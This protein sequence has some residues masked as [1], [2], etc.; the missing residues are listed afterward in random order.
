VLR[1]TVGWQFHCLQVACQHVQGNVPQSGQSSRKTMHNHI[2]QA[3]ENYFID[4]MRD[5]ELYGTI[6]LKRYAQLPA[7]LCHNMSTSVCPNNHMHYD[8]IRDLSSGAGAVPESPDLMPD[9]KTDN[10]QTSELGHLATKEAVRT[11]PNVCFSVV[12]T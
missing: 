10:L 11:G 7:I 12:Q 1:S 8:D 2:N 3:I 5:R 6:Y 9:H 4:V